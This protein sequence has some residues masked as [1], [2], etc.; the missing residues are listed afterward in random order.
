MRASAR[1][2]ATVSLPS[3]LC[4][5]ASASFS[6][7]DAPGVGAFTATL[8]IRDARVFAPVAKAA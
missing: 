8:K 4:S 7:A 3:A 1:I 5:Q 6:D 2:S